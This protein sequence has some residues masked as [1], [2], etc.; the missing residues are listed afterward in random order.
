MYSAEYSHTI[1][2]FHMNNTALST[3]QSVLRIIESS[4]L[5]LILET[6]CNKILSY[7]KNKDKLI[8]MLFIEYYFMDD[9][10]DFSTTWKDLAKTK[11]MWNPMYSK[12]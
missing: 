11:Y 9:K 10:P 8:R 6:K 12:F 7:L 1:N 3:P 5:I 2:L 4:E